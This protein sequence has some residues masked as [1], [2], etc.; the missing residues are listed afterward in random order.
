MFD[1]DVRYARDAFEGL[2]VMDRLGEI[3]RD[4]SADD[5]EWG[6]TPSDST[7]PSRVKE[8]FAGHPG[9][10]ETPKG[11]DGEEDRRNLATLTGLAGVVD[12]SL[13]ATP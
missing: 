2:R 1:G 10:L 7:V 8:R 6:R 13:V 3:R 4:P 11:D 5:P 9:I 12:A